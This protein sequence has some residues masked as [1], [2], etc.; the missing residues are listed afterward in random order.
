[1]VSTL[2]LRIQNLFEDIKRDLKS[3][4]GDKLIKI[5]LFGSY[6]RGDYNQESD[7]DI[8]VLVSEHLPDKFHK[9]ILQINVDLSLK[10][11]VDLSII[12]KNEVD[13]MMNKEIIPLYKNVNQEGL[14]I[15]AA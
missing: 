9:N 12:I 7:I 2:E 3:L 14:D 8:F 10:Y 11:D 13:F 15:Y 6:A 5:I 1:M 4:F